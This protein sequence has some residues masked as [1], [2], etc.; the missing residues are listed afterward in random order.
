MLRGH[1]LLNR[2]QRDLLLIFVV[3]MHVRNPRLL[4]HLAGQFAESADKMRQLE[5]K[6][7]NSARARNVALPSGRLDSEAGLSVLGSAICD[8]GALYPL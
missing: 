7:A 5:K 6:M 4:D 1:K 3:S 8:D 2:A